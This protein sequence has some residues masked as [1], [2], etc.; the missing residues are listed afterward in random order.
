MLAV[1]CSMGWCELAAMQRRHM[2]LGQSTVRIQVAVVELAI[3]DAMGELA[4]TGLKPAR[5]SGTQRAR[6]PGNP[7]GRARDEPDHAREL[8]WGS[9][10]G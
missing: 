6:K 10:S 8:G 7:G 5:P 1:F 4:K 9:G 3:A 2:D